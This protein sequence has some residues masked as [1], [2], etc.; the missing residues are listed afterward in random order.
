MESEMENYEK[1][2][3]AGQKTSDLIHK[4]IIMT[5]TNNFV[6]WLLAILLKQTRGCQPK[7]ITAN[8]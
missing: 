2:Y 7:N 3:K 5:V 8:K 4:R 6:V 1:L